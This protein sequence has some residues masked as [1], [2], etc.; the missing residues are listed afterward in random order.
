MENREWHFVSPI[1]VGI[2]YKEWAAYAVNHHFLYASEF[3]HAN[4][5]ERQ[6]STV[7]VEPRRPLE[8]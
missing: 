4:R 2:P 8:E 1:L 5:P 7:G 3:R 6:Q